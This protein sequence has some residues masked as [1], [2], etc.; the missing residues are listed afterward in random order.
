M[1]LVYCFDFNSV[2][3]TILLLVVLISVWLFG[4]LD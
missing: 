2:V 3:V 4:L 1:V